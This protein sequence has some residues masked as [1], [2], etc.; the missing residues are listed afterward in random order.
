MELQFL[1][2]SAFYIKTSNGSFVIDP[3][4]SG[5]PS[6]DTDIEKINVDDVLLTHGHGDH[7]GDAIEIA[8]KNNATITAIFEIANYCS[9]Q[10]VETT[11]LNFG[12]KVPYKW[13]TAALV[14]AT[15]SSSLPDGSYAGCPG[16]YVMDID[17]KTLYHTGDTGLTYEFKMIKEYYKPEIAM[18]PIGGFYTM[19][20]DEAIV[21]AEWLG[22]K[23]V[24]P[25]HYNTFPP[26]KTDVNKFAD[27]LAKKSIKCHILSPGESLKI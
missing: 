17:G 15:H 23:E 25:M 18:L 2:H 11:G 9:K 3:F 27:L 8:K 22:V 14:P 1:G 13:G 19:G 26:I 6:C 5:N 21:A 20:I 10:G 7:I 12:S 16:G 24:I 4:M